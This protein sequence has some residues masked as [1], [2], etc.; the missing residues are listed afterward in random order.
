MQV[1]D[2]R[3][4]IR[5]PG[6]SA[7]ERYTDFVY[8]ALRD[9]SGTITGVVTVGV[10]VTDRRRAEETLHESEERSAFVRRS[11]GVGFWY[12]DLPLDVLQWDDLVKSHFHLSPDAEVTIDTL[13]DRIHPDD[14]E[15][16]RLAIKRS[17]AGHTHYNVDYRTVNP[18]TGGVRWVRAIGRTFYAADGTPTRF[19]GVSLDVSDHKRSEASSAG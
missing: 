5:Q 18:E 11:T 9:S 6:Q 14:R 19:D 17:I 13:Y 3:S 10:D 15:L 12:C 8:Q 2:C 1:A 7:E 16:P 4:L